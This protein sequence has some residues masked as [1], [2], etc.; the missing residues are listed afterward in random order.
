MSHNLEYL[1]C[2]F[3]TRPCRG[4]VG[5]WSHMIQ[6]HREK[7]ELLRMFTPPVQRQPCEVERDELLERIRQLESELYHTDWIAP[8]EFGLTRQEQAFL[9]C[10]LTREMRSHDSI[11]T[12]ISNGNADVDSRLSQVVACKVRRKLKPYGIDVQRVWGIGY[13]ISEDARQ[14]LLNWNDR[15]EKAA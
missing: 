10:L 7:I 4:H 11:L 9:A 3:C 6:S 5:L 14:R 8:S 13:R 15:A 12:A 1:D 2:P